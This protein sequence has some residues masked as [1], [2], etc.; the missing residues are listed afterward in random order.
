MCDLFTLD[1]L[2]GFYPFFVLLVFDTRI[3]A[4]LLADLH[5]SS[6]FSLR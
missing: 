1:F 4:G 2:I 3:K 5:H 6:H